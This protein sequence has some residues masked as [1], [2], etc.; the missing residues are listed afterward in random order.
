MYN[1]AE[2]AKRV[3]VYGSKL[4]FQL[5]AGPGRVTGG[6]IEGAKEV[7]PPISASANQAFFKPDVK[8]R[9]LSTLEVEKLVEAFG[10]AA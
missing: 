1:Y 8:C 7:V 6:K 4:F 3:H 5:S 2:L 10:D 9:P